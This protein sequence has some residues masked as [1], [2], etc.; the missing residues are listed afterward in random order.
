M[1]PELTPRLVAV[2]TKAM[3]R[4]SLVIA[5]EELAPLAAVAPSGVEARVV[6]AVQVVKRLGQ[7]RSNI[8]CVPL[9]FGAVAPRFVAVEVNV[10]KITPDEAI[11]GLELE[12]LAGVTPSGVETR[13]DVGAQ[14]ALG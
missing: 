14:E 10:T 7:L 5:D 3:N 1:P 6:T 13:K 8:S 9:G 11:A 4:P 12:P 2:D